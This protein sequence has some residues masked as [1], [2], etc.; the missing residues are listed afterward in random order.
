MFVVHMPTCYN[1][2]LA[3]YFLL[4]SSNFYGFIFLVLTKIHILV[5]LYTLEGKNLNFFSNYFLV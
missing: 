1:Y 2:I 4:P 5:Y 3:E